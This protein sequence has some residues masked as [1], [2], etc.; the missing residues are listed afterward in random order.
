M[1]IINII[2]YKI[3]QLDDGTSPFL[4]AQEESA[5]LASNTADVIEVL[6]YHDVMIRLKILRVFQGTS[7]V[8]VRPTFSTVRLVGAHPA[9]TPDVTTATSQWCSISA[10]MVALTPAWL[11][12]GH[13]YWLEISWTHPDMFSLN[14]PECKSYRFFV[15]RRQISNTN[16]LTSSQPS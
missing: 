15:V 5:I 1:A 7:K 14:P 2:V 12:C 8:R 3:I 16:S 10:P 9:Y 13:Q 6:W 11:F 4:D